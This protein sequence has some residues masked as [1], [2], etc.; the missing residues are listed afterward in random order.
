MYL[1]GKDEEA[2][3]IATGFIRNPDFKPIGVWERLGNEG[4]VWDYAAR[5][6]REPSQR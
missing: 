2:E 3:G 6:Y 1:A 4:A 5:T